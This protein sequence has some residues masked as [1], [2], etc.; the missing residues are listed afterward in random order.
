M[1]IELFD[2]C[3]LTVGDMDFSPIE[4]LGNVTFHDIV[5]PQD[6]AKTIGDADIALVNKA[7]LTEEVFTRCPNLKYVG[8]FATGYN[9]IDLEAAKRHG[10][11]VCNVPGYSTDSVTQHV[12]AL[13]L[14]IA[15]SIGQYDKSVHNGDWVKSLAFSYFPYPIIEIRDKTFG[16]F[17]FGSIGKAVAKVADAFDMKVIIC[18]RTKPENCPY[19]LVSKEEL[20]A[21]SD[22]LTIHSPLTPQTKE[23]VNKDTLALMKPTAVLINTARG[24]VVNEQDLADALNDGKIAAA[25]LD[26]LTVEPMKADN[27]LLKA[28]NCVITPHTAWASK[29][30]RQRLIGMVAGNI[31]AFMDE[32]PI[33]VVS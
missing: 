5:P 3:T 13:L 26:V 4:A 17:G 33:N 30:A 10:I 31:K 32:K 6:L 8:I 24:G 25:G 11:T 23:L 12:F 20:F 19:E 7:V 27:P 15:G 16:I 21:H 29:E 18:T 9:N 22:F 14:Q 1:K 2:K 28:K